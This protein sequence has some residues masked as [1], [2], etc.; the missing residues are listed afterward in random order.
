MILTANFNDI[1][2]KALHLI[3]VTGKRAVDA[4]GNSL[5]E[6]VVPSTSDYALFEDF[7]RTAIMSLVV[8]LRDH[9]SKQSE[10]TGVFSVE[11]DMPSDVNTNLF[12]TLQLGFTSYCVNYCLWSWLSIVAPTFSEKYLKEAADFSSYVLIQ[13]NS[14]SNP[15]VTANPLAAK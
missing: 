12:T 11:L 10:D 7:T 1:R 3:S 2:D 15:T 14:R 5:Y 13:A 6:T 4:K 8:I 9:V